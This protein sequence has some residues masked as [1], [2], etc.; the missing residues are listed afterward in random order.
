[1][2]VSVQL[3]LTIVLRVKQKSKHPVSLY[4]TGLVSLQMYSSWKS[5]VPLFHTDWLYTKNKPLTFPL[6]IS[7][8]VG[9]N[10]K[11]WNRNKPAILMSSALPLGLLEKEWIRAPCPCSQTRRLM[12]F[13]S[14]QIF[15]I[16]LKRRKDRRDRMLRTLYEQ[17]IAVKIVE[18][19]D[20]K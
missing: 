17:E 5:S 14:T 1:M 2:W 10:S 4:N 12:S 9:T 8:N 13:S 20:G 18:A 3:E 6:K 7:P 16:N 19:V 11:V 15:M